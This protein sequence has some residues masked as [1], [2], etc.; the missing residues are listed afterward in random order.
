MLE[1]LG[2][3]KLESATEDRTLLEALAVVREHQHS[4]ADWIPKSK[5]RLPFASVRWR[6]LIQ[7]PEDAT[8]W[9]RRQLEICVLSQVAEQ[10]EVGNLCVA[11][12]DSFS[13]PRQR[14]LSWEACEQRWPEYCERIRIPATADEFVKE[15]RRQLQEKAEAVDRGLPTNA[16]VTIGKDG[17]PVLRKSVAQQISDTALRLEAE[18]A[19]RMLRR[20][21]LEIL[22][23]AQHLTNFTRHFGPGSGAEPKLRSATERY[24]LTVFAMGSHLGR[25]RRRAIWRAWLRRTCCRS[26]TSGM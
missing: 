2:V 14:L 9:N 22:V 4:R 21:L 5:M 15:L 16:E 24:L 1:A 25:C 19:V 7:H 18:L 17:E 11:G 6:K 12:S 13:D 10:L 26:P 23:N 3:L 20:T 8:L